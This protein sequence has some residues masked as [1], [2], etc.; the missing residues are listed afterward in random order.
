VQLVDSIIDPATADPAKRYRIAFRD[1]EWHMWDDDSEIC[2]YEGRRSAYFWE[3]NLDDDS[4]ESYTDDEIIV[5]GE[6]AHL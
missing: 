3:V 5:L 6:L 2:G 4:V 1:D